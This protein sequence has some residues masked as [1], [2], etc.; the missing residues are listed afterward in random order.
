MFDAKI[1]EKELVN[2][3]NIFKLVKNSDFN[4][5]LKSLA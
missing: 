5:T 3:S 1:K 4:K 2:K